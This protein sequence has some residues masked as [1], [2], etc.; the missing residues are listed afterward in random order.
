MICFAAK[1]GMDAGKC[2]VVY[3]KHNDAKDL[4]AK[5]IEFNKKVRVI[6]S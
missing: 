4:E 5:I 3:F 2:T 6:Y 1:K